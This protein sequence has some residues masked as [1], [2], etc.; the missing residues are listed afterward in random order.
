MKQSAVPEI[1]AR[2]AEVATSG[3]LAERAGRRLRWARDQRG[4][5]LAELECGTAGRIKASVVGA[6]ER[7]ERWFGNA[8][9]LEVLCAVLG[10]TPAWVFSGGE[11]DDRSP[12]AELLRVLADEVAGRLRDAADRIC[13]PA[14]PPLCAYPLDENEGAR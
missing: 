2:F 11:T 8:D 5:S 4:W 12:D 1:Y 7:G 3:E 13:P 14:G 9:T 6:Y 10:V